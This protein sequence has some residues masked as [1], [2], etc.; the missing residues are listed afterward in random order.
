MSVDNDLIIKLIYAKSIF[1]L[2]VAVYLIN[3]H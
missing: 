2:T 1:Q 3:F